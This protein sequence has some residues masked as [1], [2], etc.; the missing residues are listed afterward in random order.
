MRA[1][2]R[3]LRAADIPVAYTEGFSPRVR[4]S[5][6][7]PLPVGVMGSAEIVDVE[8]R[9]RVGLR[10]LASALNERLPLGLRIREAEFV[11]F[12][13]PSASAVSS[14]ALYTAE[15]SPALPLPEDR[16]AVAIAAVHA[17]ET[18][19]VTR[20]SPKGEKTSDLKTALTGI[21]V[22]QGPEGASIRF[23]LRTGDGG[24]APRLAL[25]A[26]FGL[27]DEESHHLRI[28]RTDLRQNGG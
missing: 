11:P 12:L 10:R 8:L 22:A 5:F 20:R 1:L 2:E 26:L 15:P 23:S 4:L 7:P 18:F 24:L 19:P 21:S 28:T 9:E 3:A 14:E 13:T 17:A 6:G 16:V 27:T 25:Q